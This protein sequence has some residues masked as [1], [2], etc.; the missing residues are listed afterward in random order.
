MHIAYTKLTICG[1]KLFQKTS[2]QKKPRRMINTITVHGYYS[3]QYRLKLFSKIQV[4]YRVVKTTF[5]LTVITILVTYRKFEQSV[6][7]L[8]SISVKNCGT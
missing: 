4:N 1:F 5:V 3:M 8:K 2:A 6:L 7:I